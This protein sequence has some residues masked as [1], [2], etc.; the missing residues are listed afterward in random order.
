VAD[1]DP[2]LPLVLIGF[3]FSHRVWFA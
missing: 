2:A 1:D 3:V